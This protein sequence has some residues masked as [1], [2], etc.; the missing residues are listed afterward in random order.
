MKTMKISN[1]RLVDP[2]IS[3]MSMV[4]QKELSNILHCYLN[5]LPDI[6]R[7]VITLIDLYDFDYSEAADILKIPLG[8]IKSRLARARLQMNKKLQISIDP[9]QNYAMFEA[10]LVQ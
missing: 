3:V 10:Q 7:S 1:R 2:A 5:E 9:S 4:E 8:T 6:F